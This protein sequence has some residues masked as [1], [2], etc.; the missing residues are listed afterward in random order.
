[1]ICFLRLM[2]T[3]L[4]AAVTL[5]SVPAVLSAFPQK[6]LPISSGNITGSSYVASS[7]I[8]KIFNRRSTDYGVRLSSLPSQ[9]SVANVESVS[10]GQAAF[11]IAQTEL[12]QQA[13][14][15]RGP[16][17]GKAQ[18][19][20]R[21]VLNLPVEAVTVVA[22]ADA[23]IS[24]VSDLKGKRVNIGAAGSIDNTYAANLLILSGLN[25][26]DVSLSE[27]PA[28]LASELLQKSEIDA[29]IYTVCHP[30][31]SVLE[32]SAGPRKVLLVPIDKPL[33]ELVTAAN[34]LLLPAVVPTDF[35][36]GLE[37]R[38]VVPS[39]GVRSVL[40]TRADMAEETVFRLVRD[41]M[42]NFDLFRRQ[43]PALQSLTPREA[44]EATVIPAHPGAARYFRQAGLV[45]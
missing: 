44:A 1:M 26:A 5:L 17:E 28:A 41:I 27:H 11:G 19:D 15:G 6:S 36:P 8:A 22:A 21:A 43:H 12:L 16:W 24:R 31:L 25:P 7:A 30:N 39:I 20:L 32:A 40:F 45:P 33:I 37:R 2:R 34:P 23:G 9:G 29:Y 35:Y 13:A 42:T 3:V 10:G 14:T 38:G 4:L 18:G